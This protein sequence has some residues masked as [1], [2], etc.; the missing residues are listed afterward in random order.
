MVEFA[1]ANSP[2][3][4]QQAFAG[5]AFNTLWYL[6]QIAPDWTARFVSRV[7]QDQ[8]SEDMLAMMTR[9]GVD[10]STVAR[11]PAHTVGLYMIALQDGERSFSYWRGQSAARHLADDIAF[12][13]AALD[14]I[15][16]IF[17]SGITIAILDEQARAAFLHVVSAQ[18]AKG[19]TVVFDPNLRP[20]LWKDPAVMRASIMDGARVSDLILPSF[21]EEAEFF[22]DVSMAATCT[23][24]LDAG[25]DAVVVKNGGGEVHYDFLGRT[26]IVVPKPVH[27]IVD[28]TSAGDSF[29]SGFLAG[30]GRYAS[31]EAAIDL[32]SRMAG[33]VIGQ[34]GALCTLD[35]SS[36]LAG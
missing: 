35:L 9:Q 24:Y 32:A 36:E 5:D 23:R 15:D 34:K 12:V 1:P 28:T 14:D 4:F 16:V 11:D 13:D 19:K 21:D 6:R 22:G 27:T 7:G 8:I 26:G 17:F 18:R 30:L 3:Q 29:N 33:Q 31:V 10:V 2:G 25:A 20:R